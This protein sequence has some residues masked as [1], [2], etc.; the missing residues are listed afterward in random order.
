MLKQVVIKN[1]KK[2]VSRCSENFEY[3][4]GMFNSNYSK[5]EKFSQNHRDRESEIKINLIEVNN[6]KKPIENNK[7][8]EKI[9]N[10]R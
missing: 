4:K 10:V 5:R 6:A 1:L 3:F 2:L 9:L 8:E 7:N